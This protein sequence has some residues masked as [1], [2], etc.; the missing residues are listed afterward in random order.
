MGATQMTKMIIPTPNAIFA[1]IFYNL[2]GEGRFSFSADDFA[3]KTTDTGTY[4]MVDD[5]NLYSPRDRQIIDT[6]KE[7]IYNEPP[8]LRENVGEIFPDERYVQSIRTKLESVMPG[9]ANMY[10]DVLSS[11]Q[12]GFLYNFPDAMI[13][14][15]M[16][17][18]GWVFVQKNPKKDSDGMTIVS[19]VYEFKSDK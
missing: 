12:F 18:N 8:Q 7:V 2:I 19:N 9:L 13:I 6:L 1:A 17:D 10:V 16:L 5:R 14:K 4:L 15:H 3:K 11:F